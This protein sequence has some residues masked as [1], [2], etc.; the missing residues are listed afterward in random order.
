[1]K[2]NERGISLVTTALGSMV[3]KLVKRRGDVDNLLHA[4]DL[5]HGLRDVLAETRNSIT[6]DDL[7]ATFP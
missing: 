6:Y 5:L 1:M 3:E 2:Q 4:Y 7:W